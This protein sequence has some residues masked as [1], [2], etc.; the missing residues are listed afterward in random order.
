M[1]TGL[2]GVRYQDGQPWCALIGDT[3]VDDA[4][5]SFVNYGK[6]V[7]G[8]TLYDTPDLRGM[9]GGAMV[10][11]EGAPRDVTQPLSA[12][13]NIKLGAIIVEKA[14]RFNDRPPLMIATS[15]HSVVAMIESATPDEQ[16]RMAW[17]ATMLNDQPTQR[18]TI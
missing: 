10:R 14:E 16:T 3:V 11:I 15:I 18:D 6:T 8:T 9:S 12:S 7:V 2:F 4:S 1:P 13:T 5:Q 17:V